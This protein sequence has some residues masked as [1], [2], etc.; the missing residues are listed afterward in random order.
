MKTSDT[1]GVIA[2]PP[3]VY[4]SGLLVAFLIELSW[5]RIYTGLPWEFRL[6]LAAVLGSAGLSLVVSAIHCFHKAKTN[7]RPWLPTT[8]LVTN[9]VYAFTR[10][11]MYVAMTCFYLSLALLVDSLTALALLP[12][13]LLTIR[14]GVIAREERYLIAKFGEPYREYMQQVARWIL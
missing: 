12:L 10:N 1:P 11:P 5:R 13:V 6:G 4:L 9:G 14:F 8:A 7:A 2:P 3:L